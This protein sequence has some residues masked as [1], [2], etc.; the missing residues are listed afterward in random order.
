VST[1]QY[2]IK[3]SR[4]SDRRPKRQMSG[5]LIFFLVA[6]ALFAGALAGMEYAQGLGRCPAEDSCVADYVGNRWIIKSTP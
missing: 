1:G 4:P 3:V 5:V 6:F 2:G